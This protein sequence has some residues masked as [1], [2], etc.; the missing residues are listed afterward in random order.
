MINS[1][2]F[3]FTCSTQSTYSIVIFTFFMRLYFFLA[4]TFIKVA[5]NSVLEANITYP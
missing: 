5:Q 3:Y 1:H 4:Y 2:T